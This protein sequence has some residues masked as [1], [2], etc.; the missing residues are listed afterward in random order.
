MNKDTRPVSPDFSTLV[1]VASLLCCWSCPSLLGAPSS[2]VTGRL[3][4]E[5]GIAA[6]SQSSPSLHRFSPLD[7]PRAS[8][9][10]DRT[11]P[12]YEV[13]FGTPPQE[14]EFLFYMGSASDRCWIA[15]RKIA[16]RN[17]RAETGALSSRPLPLSEPIPDPHQPSSF[18]DAVSGQNRHHASFFRGLPVAVTV[19]E[20]VLT[21]RRRPHSSEMAIAGLPSEVHLLLDK[22]GAVFE[23]IIPEYMAGRAP[24]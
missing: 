24:R 8:D 5:S 19:T 2:T 16:G 11:V 23:G 3:W 20:K 22:S 15:E 21:V 6:P 1:I 14:F 7:W 13:R 12:V 18:V 9:T 10:N 4:G 17:M